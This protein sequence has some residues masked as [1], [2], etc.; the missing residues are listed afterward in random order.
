MEIHYA[1]GCDIN[2]K[3]ETVIQHKWM[4]EKR[5]SFF[6]LF[7]FVAQS[8]S[9]HFKLNWLL[10]I[11]L[12]QY[13]HTM[14]IVRSIGCAHI[15]IDNA[16]ISFFLSFLALSFPT[17]T[18]ANAIDRFKLESRSTKSI[19]IARRFFFSFSIIRNDLFERAKCKRKMKEHKQDT[20]INSYLHETFSF[21]GNTKLTEFQ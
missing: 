1:N 4:I 8:T 13:A 20:K 16:N 9:C 11:I 15:S 5:L 21:F 17:S 6:L 3:I 2:S 10:R 14:C 18:F 12:F 7:L 19:S